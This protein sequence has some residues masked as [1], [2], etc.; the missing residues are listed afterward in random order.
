M[1]EFVRL[2]ALA[3]TTFLI[4]AV[5]TIL[6]NP[7]LSRYVAVGLGIAERQVGEAEPDPIRPGRD[8]LRVRRAD[9][10]LW[11]GMTGFPGTTQA[12]FHLPR[13]LEVTRAQLQ[14]VVATEMVQTGEGQLRILID[15]I[16]RHA[17]AVSPG[18]TRRELDF[19]LTAEDLSD[20]RIV[21]TLSGQGTTRLGVSCPGGP[22]GAGVVVE[23]D[24]TSRVMLQHAGGRVSAADRLVASAQP[25]L[26]GHALPEGGTAWPIWMAQFMSRMGARTV[27]VTQSAEAEATRTAEAIRHGSQEGAPI[28]I[29]ASASGAMQIVELMGGAWP[30]VYDAQWPV[31]VSTL[32]A[33][34]RTAPFSGSRTWSISYRLAD[35][36]GAQLPDRLELELTATKLDEDSG[37]GVVVMLNGDILETSRHGGASDRI[38]LSVALP[39]EAQAMMNRIDVS[40]VAPEARN[41]GCPPGAMAQLRPGSALVIDAASGAPAT[42]S[43]AAELARRLHD[44][45]PFRLVAPDDLPLMSARQAATLLGQILPLT[46]P[47]PTGEGVPAYRITVLEGSRAPEGAAI[48]TQRF[49][50]RASP[51]DDRA[52]T[53]RKLAPDDPLPALAPGEAALLIE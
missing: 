53:V 38:S 42:V 47:P 2:I 15:G 34:M 39:S 7:E 33:D 16:E 29:P 28:L 11:T 3:I 44:G 31:P 32:R 19:D 52:A 13:D 36:P 35:L 5:V 26:L 41:G 14:L 30:E 8:V 10:D 46:A 24:P 1:T 25:L 18:E 37:W 21:V 12:V 20:H 49:L 48:G 40:L 17:L 22:T 9:A 4:A 27:L 6:S 43:A 45:G 23:I 50:V 51:R